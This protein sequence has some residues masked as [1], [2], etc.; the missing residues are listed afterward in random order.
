MYNI[1]SYVGKQYS[2]ITILAKIS[3]REREKFEYLREK[4][5]RKT[6]YNKLFINFLFFRNC[7]PEKTK[8][9]YNNRVIRFKGIVNPRDPK[10]T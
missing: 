4:K 2:Q 3:K 8:N 5:N 6:F 10:T 9:R 7:I 1:L